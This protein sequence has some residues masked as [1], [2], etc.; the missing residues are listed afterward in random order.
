MIWVFL[1]LL[2]KIKIAIISYIINCKPVF[3]VYTVLKNDMIANIKIKK[4]TI[5]K[6]FKPV[7][8]K[9]KS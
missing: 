3:V 5:I 2:I 7:R 9:S 6:V 4:S 1:V 8:E